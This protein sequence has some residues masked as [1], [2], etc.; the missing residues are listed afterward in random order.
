METALTFNGLKTLKK[1]MEL[2][3]AEKRTLKREQCDLKERIKQLER[4]ITVIQTK[5][6]EDD[7]VER[8]KYIMIVWLKGNKEIDG[9]VKVFAKL[10]IKKENYKTTVLSTT[11][12][13]KPI[14][15]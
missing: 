9:N 6:F 14:L 15:N 5:T 4:D 1:T 11:E 8:K 12:G 2:F 13:N 3:M 7:T 10:S